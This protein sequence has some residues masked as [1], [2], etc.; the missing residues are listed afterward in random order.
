MT[1]IRKPSSPSL[2]TGSRPH[3]TIIQEAANV[4]WQRILPKELAKLPQ[5]N[6]NQFVILT[7]AV[8]KAWRPVGDSNP[9]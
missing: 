1:S 8:E 9:C 6:T 4:D 7:Q 5:S 3:P 2:R